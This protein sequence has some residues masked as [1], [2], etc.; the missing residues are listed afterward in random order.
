MKTNND[1]RGG[2]L[3][4]RYYAAYARYFVR[5]L[6]E[7]NKEGIAIWGITPQNEPENP[8]NQPSMEMDANEQL[9]FINNHLGPAVAASPFS[10]KI[11]AFD[12]NCDNTDYPTTV[13][14]NSSFAEGAA[15][16]LYAGNISAMS[17]V[18]DQTGKSVYF[19]EQFTSTGGDFDG[20]LGWHMENVVIGS[21]RNW[22]KTV[23]EWNLATNSDFGPRTEGGC[24]ECLGAITVN[25]SSSISRNVSYYIV[26]QLSKFVEPG[27][28]RL[29]SGGGGILNAVVRN[30]DGGKSTAGLQ[31]QQCGPERIG[32]LGR[33]IIFLQRAGAQCRHLHLGG[34]PRHHSPEPRS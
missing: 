20:D 21:L 2:R 31:S 6:E 23:I 8:F 19:T 28:V 29:A 4:P 32:E 14:N 24:T 27:A 33:P 34:D 30:P 13:L 1:S 18:H 22:S 16:H 17:T 3:Q 9:D 15:F 12:H 7:M 25:S 11:I 26:S 10:P 5:Y